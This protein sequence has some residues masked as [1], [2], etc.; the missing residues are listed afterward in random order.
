LKKIIA[1]SN[2]SFAVQVSLLKTDSGKKILNH[3]NL[4]LFENSI[5]GLIGESGC[6]K[7]SLAK[8]ISG[9]IHPTEGKIERAEKL[10]IQILFQNSEESIHPLR[11]IISILSDVSKIKS[12][13]YGICRLLGIG[14]KLLEQRGNSLS[15][16]ER[17]R[18]A[19]ARILL[20]KPDLIILDEPFSAQDPDSQNQLTNLFREIN[21]NYHCSLFIISHN[22]EPVRNLTGNIFVMLKGNIVE[23]GITTEVISNPF[24]P[25]TNFLLQAESYQQKE[26]ILTGTMKFP[27]LHARFMSTVRIKI[28]FV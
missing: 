9:I 28:M 15:G 7:T 2:V 4:E 22:I 8:I 13:I 6:G 26:K 19:L 20:N 18:V 10:N 17:Q 12:E 16:G 1:L 27:I 24:H 25:Y 14:G 23:S 5:T 3:I 11:K 21:S